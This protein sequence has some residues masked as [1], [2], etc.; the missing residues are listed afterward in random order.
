[1]SSILA[2]ILFQKLVPVRV[3]FARIDGGVAVGRYI[4]KLILRKFVVHNGYVEIDYCG[5]M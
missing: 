2:I 1:M 3:D 5:V 4:L